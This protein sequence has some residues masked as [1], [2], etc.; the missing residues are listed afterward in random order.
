MSLQFHS[1]SNVVIDFGARG[2]NVAGSLPEALAER[3]RQKVGVVSAHYQCRICALI[4]CNGPDTPRSS[5]DARYC[6]PSGK[7]KELGLLP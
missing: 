1:A 3:G 7:G 2:S 4:G 6:E 5:S